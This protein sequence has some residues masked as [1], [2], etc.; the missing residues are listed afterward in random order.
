MTEGGYLFTEG[1][2]CP[3]CGAYG[4]YGE[5]ILREGEVVY[6]EYCVYCGYEK[7]PIDDEGFM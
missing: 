6:V 1:A 2:R 5:N 4:Y 7:A 3:N